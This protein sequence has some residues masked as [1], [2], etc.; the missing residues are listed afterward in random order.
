MSRVVD[1]IDGFTSASQPVLTD[2]GNES[3]PLTNNQASFID[4][5][6]LDFTGY[7]S[8]V[9]VLEIERIGAS[10]Y[11]QVVNVNFTYDGAAWS[12]ELG[13]FDG[14]DIIQTSSI[15]SIE[16]IVLS[17]DGSQVQYKTGNISSHTS[18]KIKASLTRFQ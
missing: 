5:S 10:T 12:I 8:A 2:A 1:F 11:R 7:T 4:V 9:G 15:T 16:Q 18:S 6:G 14:F 17:M 13:A 3:Y